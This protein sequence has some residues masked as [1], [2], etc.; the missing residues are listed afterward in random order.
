MVADAFALAGWKVVYLGAD[1]P[2]QDLVEQ[3]L[4]SRPALL[5][6][7][8]SLPSQLQKV[9]ETMG[10]L[11]EKMGALRPPVIVGGLAINRFAP[12]VN[13]VGAQ[14]TGQDARAALTCADA[15]LRAD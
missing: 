2:V 12:L 5:G 10:L 11:D 8:V 4:S 6:L 14:A 1:V 3:T 15:V 7:S 9:R 13:L